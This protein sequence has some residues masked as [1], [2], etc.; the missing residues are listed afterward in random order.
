M[1]DSA[2][3]TFDRTTFTAKTYNYSFLNLTS[4]PTDIQTIKDRIPSDAEELN[5]DKLMYQFGA[6]FTQKAL[7]T[8]D[9]ILTK[10]AR[11]NSKRLFST[12]Q[13]VFRLCHIQLILNIQ[14]RRNRTELS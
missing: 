14:E 8:A 3:W 2:L 7:M 10:Q 1:N 11:P 6:T 12:L 9:D 5:K 4:D 13:M